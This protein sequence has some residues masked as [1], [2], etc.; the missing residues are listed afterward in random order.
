MKITSSSEITIGMCILVFEIVT[1]IVPKIIKNPTP[2]NILDGRPYEPE[3][4]A[5]LETIRNHKSEISELIINGVKYETSNMAKIREVIIPSNLNG[6]TVQAATVEGF[7]YSYE[8]KVYESY[9]SQENL[10]EM[11]HFITNFLLIINIGTRYKI[12]AITD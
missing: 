8:Q 9:V 7:P 3:I 2:S 6:T 5:L 10:E 4:N 11:K 12:M 1:G